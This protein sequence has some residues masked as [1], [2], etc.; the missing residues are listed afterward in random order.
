MKKTILFILFIFAIPWFSSAR[1]SVTFGTLI[2]EMTS[3]ERLT[4]LPDQ[5]YEMVQ[6]S[7]YDRRSRIPG[8]EGWFA[9]SDGFGK[10]P[11]P[12]FEKVLKEPD[13]D[14]IGTYLIC[15]IN[16][17]GAILRLW[18]AGIN[19]D[20][21]LFLDDSISPVYD[22]DALEFFHNTASALTHNRLDTTW[23]A[24]FRQFDA[25]YFPVPF[26]KK[27][28]MEWTG[29]INKI[30]FYHVGVRKYTA[31]T[32]VESFQ[33]GITAKYGDFLKEFRTDFTIDLLHKSPETKN[34]ESI[35]LTVEG[36]SSREFYNL[37]GQYAVDYLSLKIISRDMENALRSCI[38]Y[39]FFDDAVTPQVASPVGDFFGAAPGINPYDSYPFSV[40]ED[41]SM[42]CR[43]I[44]PF[45][46]SAR[47]IV[48]NP[49]DE[50]IRLSGNI[51]FRKYDWKEGKSMYFITRWKMDHGLTASNTSIADIPYYTVSGQGRLVGAAAFIYNP[52]NAVTSWGN[53][54]GEGDEKIYIDNRSFPAFFGTGSED[55]FNYSWSSESIFQYP[56]CG[57]SRNDGPGNRGYV[58]NYRWHILDDLFFRDFLSFYME[59]FHHDVVPG[60]SYGRIIYGYM[61]PGF[62]DDYVPISDPGTNPVNYDSWEPKAYLGS[63]GY[64]FF[65]AEDLVESSSSAKVIEE[66]MASGGRILMWTPSMTGEKLQFIVER[67]ATEQYILGFT[68][69]KLPGGGN[70]TVYLNGNPVRLN[71]QDNIDLDETGRKIL[72]NYFSAPVSFIKGRNEVVLKNMGTTGRNKTGIDFI[73]LKE[74]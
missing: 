12:A 37:S 41:N 10:E 60:F 52:S 3:L 2:R 29:N 59:L 49:T 19:G 50:D 69:Q 51:H 53:W 54:W 30:H 63:A 35:N 18:T 4:V 42:V 14:G 44:M 58:S 13:T 57:Q 46:K 7:S 22:G 43:F 39:I 23:N 26:S 31:G 73:W 68:F 55:Y 11:V 1:E 65:Q 34:T 20:L 74:K 17:P 28:R 45:K 70:F 56:Y 5:P 61:L 6:F 27:C 15:D 25:T 32:A 47:F 38:L 8:M 33:P 24:L 64:S 40:L 36:N 9:N 48:K 71:K 16:G 66:K 21:K 62:I 72:R 67:P